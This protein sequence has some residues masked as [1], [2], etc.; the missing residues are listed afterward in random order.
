MHE[1]QKDSNRLQ[2]QELELQFKSV[3]AY[4]KACMISNDLRATVFFTAADL[5]FLRSVV[6]MVATPCK[7]C[8][9]LTET[10]IS[11]LAAIAEE[12]CRQGIWRMYYAGNR[13]E[14]FHSG[15]AVV[16]GFA[17]DS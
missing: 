16:D 1:K 7:L 9:L 6:C 3:S 5:K 2:Q 8:L 14:L 4:L 10:Q 17:D 13:A 11:V 12:K 15:Y